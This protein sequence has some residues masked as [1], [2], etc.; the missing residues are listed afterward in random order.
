MTIL[1]IVNA[2]GGLRKLAMQ[3][4][5]VREAWAVASLIDRLNPLLRFA[6]AEEMKAAGDEAKLEALWSMEPEDLRGLQPIRIHADG[7]RLSASDLK[8]LA[9]L[10]EFLDLGGD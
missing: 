8:L 2:S 10:V 3:D 7:L 9:P 4:L 5:P 6:G 1:T